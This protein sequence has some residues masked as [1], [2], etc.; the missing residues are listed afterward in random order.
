MAVGQSSLSLSLS[1]SAWSSLSHA[2]EM[3]ARRRSPTASSSMAPHASRLYFCSLVRTPRLLTYQH[4]L[5]ATGCDGRDGE[6]TDDEWPW[7]GRWSGR[8]GGGGHHALF[9][10]QSDES[11]PPRCAAAGA[12]CAVRHGLAR[13][14]CG[15]DPVRRRAGTDDGGRRRS[16]EEEEGRSPSGPLPTCW[17]VT[18]NILLTAQNRRLLTSLHLHSTTLCSCEPPGGGEVRDIGDGERGGEEGGSAEGG[19]EGQSGRSLGGF[20][21]MAERVGASVSV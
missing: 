9:C 5:A 21:S 15:I 20:Y 8:R 18:P 2:C 13:R 14:L 11:W 17:P 4:A 19:K 16:A 1:L 7:R 6:N 3:K 10:M 12:E